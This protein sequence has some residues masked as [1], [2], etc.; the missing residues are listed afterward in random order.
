MDMSDMRC[1][2]NLSETDKKLHAL[3][4]CS[5]YDFDATK[6]LDLLQNDNVHLKSRVTPMSVG[7]MLHWI[8]H[9]A[10]EENRILDGVWK[11]NP[12]FG[13]SDWM[14]SRTCFAEAFCSENYRKAAWFMDEIRKHQGVD[15][16]R[17]LLNT[18]DRYGKFPITYA[19]LYFNR[20]N[21]EEWAVLRDVVIKVGFGGGYVN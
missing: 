7:T 11:H 1:C 21:S 16:L 17:N 4:F 5:I 19:I 3:L 13:W 10:S 9:H 15:V 6:V 20:R 8:V 12:D 18:P 14:S 2:A